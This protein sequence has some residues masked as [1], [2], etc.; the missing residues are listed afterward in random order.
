MID[1]QHACR[2]HIDNTAPHERHSLERA[3]VFGQGHTMLEIATAVSSPKASRLRY[4]T[5][6]LQEAHAEREAS[7]AETQANAERLAQESPSR[8]AEMYE[9]AL[10]SVPCELVPDVHEEFA[11]VAAF[12]MPARNALRAPRVRSSRHERRARASV[13]SSSILGEGEVEPPSPVRN[14]RDEY[15]VNHDVLF[16]GLAELAKL[17]ARHLVPPAHHAAPSAPLIYTTNKRGPY[18]PGKS[19]RWML[20]HIPSMPG[21]HKVGRDW[22][23]RAVDYD[24]WVTAEDARRCKLAG[25]KKVSG[26]VS[27]AARKASN[28]ISNEEDE[29]ELLRRAERSLRAQGFRRS[30]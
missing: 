28:D 11:L 4:G 30:R 20:E 22:S 7:R 17:F 24:D 10:A 23:I 5:F 6:S 13:A 8:R 1:A 3:C 27:T 25:L 12:A 16:A 21:A 19:R 15:G 9:R 2:L 26:V 29:A 14:A 18:L